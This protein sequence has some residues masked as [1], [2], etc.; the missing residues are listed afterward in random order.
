MIL[1]TRRGGRPPA[2]RGARASRA[3]AGAGP[4]R[5]RGRRVATRSAGRRRA[6]AARLRVHSV[7]AEPAASAATTAAG[8]H[9]R[10]ARSGRRRPAPPRLAAGPA[11]DAVALGGVPH[12][13]DPRRRRGGLVERLA[14]PRRVCEPRDGHPS[15]P[16]RRR[17]GHRGSDR[18]GHHLLPGVDRMYVM[19]NAVLVRSQL[20]SVVLFPRAVLSRCRGSVARRAR[21]SGSGAVDE[22]VP[23]RHRPPSFTR[24]LGM[25]RAGLAVAGRVA[26]SGRP[27]RRK[28]LCGGGSTC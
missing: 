16:A 28:H 3:G 11:R 24:G 6:P 10:D 13:P 23:E 4:R 25:P 17:P 8:A 5:D 21:W 12:G 15:R 19:R 18:P 9:T 27:C 26:R 7:D 2:A 20:R 14:S 1:R 22:L